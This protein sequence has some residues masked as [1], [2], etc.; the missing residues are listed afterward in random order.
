MRQPGS[1]D[2]SSE[3]APQGC[4]SGTPGDGRFRS[5]AAL[6]P[7]S[8]MLAP[9]LSSIGLGLLMLFTFAV[10][11]QL[12]PLRL[13]IPAWQLRVAGVLI[14]RG[15]LALLGLA[16]L[17]LAAHLDPANALIQARWQRLGRL[18]VVAVL[19]FLLMVPLQLVAAVAALQGIS[20]NQRDQQQRVERNLNQ[21]RQQIRGASSFPELQQRIRQIKAPD[22][23][24]EADALNRPFPQLQ[25]FLLA[26]VDRSEQQLRRRLDG[27]TSVPIW[28]VLERS[29]RG[30]VSA[31]VLGLCFAA[32]T[33]LWSDSEVSLLMAWQWYWRQLW[34]R[35]RRQA[36]SVS[37]EEYLR[38]VSKE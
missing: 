32:A 34:R 14:D 29:G 38:R 20:S 9:A 4:P 31:L 35:R 10:L 13:L 6:Q 17:Q 24:V 19:G 21:L 16:L 5:D 28:T 1:A 8:E 7:P 15:P 23:V 18:G 22:L 2:T 3:S 37:Q 26:S 25:R 11:S 33:P 12:F 30:V 27:G 36:A